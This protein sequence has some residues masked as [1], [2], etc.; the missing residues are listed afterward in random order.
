VKLDQCVVGSCAN[1]TVED[2]MVVAKVLEG[3]RVAPWVRF[4]VTPGSMEVYRQA[5][6]RGILATI[7][8]AGALITPSACGACAAQ[9]FG[10]LAPGEVCLS[11]TTRNY[12]GRMGSSEARIYLA[13][14]ATVAASAVTGYITHPDELAERDA[15]KPVEVTG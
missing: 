3:R 5:A 12:K 10:A 14:P 11:A 9:D 6:E 4:I 13:S 8:A 7:A 1:G 2:L 15:Q